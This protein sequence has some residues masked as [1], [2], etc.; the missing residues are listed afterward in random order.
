MT[1][2]LPCRAAFDVVSQPCA[3]LVCARRRP[4]SVS[5]RR[6]QR[7][8]PGSTSPATGRRRCTRTRW[9]AA[10]GPEL[11]DYGGFPINEAGRL[12][13]LSY[14]ASRVTLR[15][16]QCDGYVAPYSMRSH[17]QRARLGGARPAHAAADRDSLVQPDVRRTPHDLDGRP[18]ASA[19]VG[20]AHVDGLL[21]RTFRRQRARGADDASQ[22]GLA[23]AQRAARERSGDAGRVL[24]PP[25]RSPDAYL[26]RS[27]IRCTSPSR[28]SEAPTSPGSPSIIRRGCSRATTASRFWAAPPTTCRTTRS[29]RTRS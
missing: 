23:A 27:P 14:D 26:G 21:D 11:G 22:A 15:H 19:G 29:A 4:G 12:F 20:A 1:Q 6:R 18:S 5:D 25:R 7:P 17:R 10:P 2:S 28:R 9:S 16:H 13:A 24:R 8:A 3:V